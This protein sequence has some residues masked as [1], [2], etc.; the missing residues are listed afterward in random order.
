M[1]REEK[2][3]QL[4]PVDENDPAEKSVIRLGGTDPVPTLLP[5]GRVHRERGPLPPEPNHRLEVPDKDEVEL[6]THEPSVESIIAPTESEEEIMERG[7]GH[8]AARHL[9]IPWGWFALIGLAMAGAMLWGV[10]SLFE[11]EDQIEV[12]RTQVADR[13][14]VEEQEEREA[15]EL[16]ERIETA[17]RGMFAAGSP[18]QMARWIRQPERVLPLIRAYYGNGPPD[19]GT[20]ARFLELQPITLARRADF[21]AARVRM[22]TGA[23]MDLL[24]EA[25]A[26]GKA[27]VDWET[28]VCHQPM[29][30][31]EYAKSRPE[32]RPLDFRVYVE[33]EV[34]FSHEFADSSR[35][36]PYKLTT[37]H[38]DEMLYGYAPV[39]GETDSTLHQLLRENRGRPVSLI[40][41]LVI[42]EGLESPRGVV[43]EKILSRHWVYVDP[44]PT[45]S[46]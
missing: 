1:A 19:H 9:P 46:P 44:P 42:P 29:P 41:R 24:V 28:A 20:V 23:K 25:P 27:L 36:S 30:W 7:W 26:D 10:N 38:G 12:I 33:P 2:R 37:L 39:D 34:L 40:L 4:R 3:I 15:A 43:I 21:W 22:S 6:R 13:F 31:D 8:E 18:E 16:I 32:G 5:A 14:D 35:W 45:P 11:G 17:V